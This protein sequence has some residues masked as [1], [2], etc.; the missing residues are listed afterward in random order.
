MI[1]KRYEESDKNIWNTFNK[2]AK[3]SLFMFD[4]N[5]M[6]Y[7]K[8]RFLDHS[9]L[10]YQDE[11]LIAILPMTEAEGVLTSHGGLT[12]GGFITNTKM[13]QHIMDECVEQLVQYARENGFR[14]L[15]YKVIPHIYH[16]QP[17]E[18]DRYAL[19]INDAKLA[20]VEASTVVNLEAPL[21][22]PKGRKA[23][24]SRAKREG[25]VIEERTDHD[26]FAQ[27]IALE[28]QVLSEHH[29]TKAVH[30]AGEINLLHDNFPGNIHL[31]AAI[32][33]NAMIAGTIV[34]EYGQV[35]H[36]QYMAANEEARQIGALD[37]TINTVIEKYKASKKWLDFGISTENGGMILNQGLISQKEGFGGRT[38]VYEM[39]KIP[40]SNK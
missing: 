35:V 31:Y 38:N 12:Y 6:D 3:N 10:F 39:W 17:A 4:R 1:I 40:T 5:Y 26:S 33:E 2:T 20:K 25:C 16:T 28:N 9:L 23:Q 18:E 30:T 29:N 22:M 15:N 34:F 32:K 7:H 14:E 27:F 11:E 8:D 36:T 37:L 13:K 24:I 21:K 19:F